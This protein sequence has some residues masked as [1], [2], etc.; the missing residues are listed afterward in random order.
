MLLY[1]DHFLYLLFSSSPSNCPT[2]L[3]CQSYRGLEWAWSSVK[4]IRNNS[5]RLSTPHSLTAVRVYSSTPRSFTPSFTHGSKLSIPH[6]F[7][8]F[9]FLLTTWP[10]L[11]GD[12]QSFTPSRDQHCLPTPPTIDPPQ[13]FSEL[14]RR[15]I[16]HHPIHQS[17]AYGLLEVNGELH[18]SFPSCIPRWSSTRGSGDQTSQ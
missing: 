8:S 14:S 7:L 5:G 12:H 6:S 17:S 13:L 15:P 18:I 11:P 9:V 16:R 10:R 4:C 1:L 2:T 3:L